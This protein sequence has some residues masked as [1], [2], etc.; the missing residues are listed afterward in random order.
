MNDPVAVEVRPL[1]GKA[2][3]AVGQLLAETK[4]HDVVDAHVALVARIAK[5]HGGELRITNRGDRSGTHAEVVSA[6]LDL[7]GES[8]LS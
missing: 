8:H 6:L 3:V 7:V 1:D 5:W 2:A 4:T